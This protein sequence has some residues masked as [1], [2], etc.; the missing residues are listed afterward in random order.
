MNVRDRI[1]F[2]T[3]FLNVNKTEFA[4]LIDVSPSAINGWEIRNVIGRQSSVK[5]S[6][7]F[8]LNFNWLLTGEG[9]PM[10]TAQQEVKEIDLSV[11][12][13][14]RVNLYNVNLSAGREI[15]FQFVSAQ[16]PEILLSKA[17]FKRNGLYP[18]NLKAMYV[19]GDSMEPFLMNGDIVMIDVSD[20]ELYDGGVFAVSYNENLYIKEIARRSD[21]I[22]LI[23]QNPKYEDVRISNLKNS[24]FI[25]LGRQVWRCG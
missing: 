13:Y 14:E 4:K 12:S 21:G 8:G 18:S 10:D 22:Y 5:I 15:G 25:V 20:T 16:Q 3:D 11:D 23:S 24:K 17:W 9:N 19:K 2:I 1:E 6:K 7:M